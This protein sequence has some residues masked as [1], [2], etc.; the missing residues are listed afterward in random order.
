VRLIIRGGK[1][2]FID[3]GAWFL[4][5]ETGFFIGVTAASGNMQYKWFEI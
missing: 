3:V 5:V 4:D 2:I 1:G